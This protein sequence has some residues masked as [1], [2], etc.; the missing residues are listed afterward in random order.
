MRKISGS[1]G[2]KLGGAFAVLLTLLAV[3][4]ATSF[5][6]MSTLTSTHVKSADVV[7]PKLLAADAV[8]AAAAD[9]HFSQTQ[10]VF[11][12]VETHSDFVGDH[13][14]FLAELANLRA[15]TTTP[16]DHAALGK[17]EAASADFD[18]ID[19][20]MWAAVRAHNY[21][22]ANKLA[23][24]AEDE[25]ADVLVNAAVSYQTEAQHEQASLTR[26]F[27]ST[28]SAANWL[29]GLLALAAMAIG[30]ALAFLLTRS[31]V[32]GIRQMLAAA[33]GIAEGD[34][35]Q[36]IETRSRD[37]V[38]QMADA[39]RRMIA[40]LQEM[41]GAAARV[42]DGDLTVHVEPRSEQDALGTATAG[43][44]TNLRD[45]MGTLTDSA[46]NLTAASV[47]VSGSATETGSAVATIAESMGD[48]AA[49]AER[50]V[51]MV[52]QAKDAAQATA[53]EAGQARELA[54]GGVAAANEATQAMLGLRESSAEVTA[55]ISAL[56]EKSSQIG[57]IV[58]TIT[59]IASQTN[60]LA[61][62]AA[63]EAARAGEQGRGFAVVAEEVRKLAE[64]AQAAAEQIGKLIGEIQADTDR[65][66]VVARTGGERTETGVEVVERARGAFEEIGHSIGQIAQ[67]IDQIA[68]ATTD[69][70]AVAV[71]SSNSVSE[72]S[73]TTQQTSAATQDIA[74]SAELLASTAEELESVVQRFQLA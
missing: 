1:L 36:R 55:A 50:Q 56:S 22:L 67:R 19:A 53:G 35:N 11:T 25:T 61:L 3:M 64:E 74:A 7:T 6:A 20:R 60:L 62:N 15:R 27:H 34:V 41:A 58:E 44:V 23:L 4:G 70:A 8:R 29:V 10:Y 51:Q 12:K 66:V 26:S 45:V 21:A 2:W 31:I 72:I 14:T 65:T 48:V 17:I 63:I 46:S 33:E 54:E 73:A 28:A 13:K 32:G 71:Q 69:V 37:E 57:G 39:F 30:I 18:R 42:A 40:Y 59:G 43:M 24:G 38:G 49:G 52:E 68:S 5:W 9:Q 47:K 16:A